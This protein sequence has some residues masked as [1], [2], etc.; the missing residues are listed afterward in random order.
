ML[1]L[2]V[3]ALS[4]ITIPVKLSSIVSLVIPSSIVRYS[5]ALAIATR[6]LCF[7]IELLIVFCITLCFNIIDLIATPKVKCFNIINLLLSYF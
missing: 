3:F 6:M 7:N 5:I 4:S 1:C 2:N